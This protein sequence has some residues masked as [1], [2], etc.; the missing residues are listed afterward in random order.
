PTNETARYFCSVQDGSIVYQMMSQYGGTQVYD[1]YG[2]SSQIVNGI[3]TPERITLDK[4][5]NV[6][7]CGDVIY[8]HPVQVFSL[9]YSLYL[10][11][12][13]DRGSTNQ[14]RI[15]QMKLYSCQIYDND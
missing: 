2:T 14:S 4:N 10:F 12:Q 6:F 1:Y 7:S 11:A 8:T 15:A 3:N 9:G 13:N 5:K